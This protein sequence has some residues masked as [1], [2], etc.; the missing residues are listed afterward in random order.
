MDFLLIRITE[1]SVTAVAKHKRE[2]IARQLPASIQ[3]GRSCVSFC[4]LAYLRQTVAAILFLIVP[5]E[6]RGH[7]T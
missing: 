7:Y 6:F 2:E 3:S 4:Q 5:L 1:Q